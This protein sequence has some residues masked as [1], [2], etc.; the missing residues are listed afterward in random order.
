M[1]EGTCAY[2]I[3]AIFPAQLQDHLFSTMLA[4]GIRIL[5]LARHI[6]GQWHACLGA[7]TI[8]VTRT[9]EDEFSFGAGGM[10]CIQDID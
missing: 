10:K 6:L 2:D 4:Y 7:K 5:R 9:D 1:I 3:H 8:L